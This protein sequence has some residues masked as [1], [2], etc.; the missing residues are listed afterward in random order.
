MVG[1]LLGQL[2]LV[3]RDVGRES[4]PS[5]VRNLRRHVVCGFRRRGE[6]FRWG[7]EGGSY[8]RA[9]LEM[10][11]SRSRFRCRSSLSSGPIP[12]QQPEGFGPGCCSGLKCCSVGFQGLG[13]SQHVLPSRA[14]EE[15]LSLAAARGGGAYYTGCAIGMG[16]A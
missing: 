7:G 10:L 11:L 8:C 3:R 5:L 9:E 4:L 2:V 6:G 15:R 16:A 14:P 13:T 1:G 12:D